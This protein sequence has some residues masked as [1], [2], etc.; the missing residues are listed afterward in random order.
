MAVSVMSTFRRI[1]TRGRAED[2]PLSGFSAGKR[3]DISNLMREKKS[4]L[5]IRDPVTVLFEPRDPDHF[6]ELR[7]NFGLIYFS[8]LMRIRDTGWKNGI[9]DGKFWIRD[10]GPG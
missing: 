5:R 3:I 4:V 8:S 10:P 1:S 9:R 7:N 6:S 2:L